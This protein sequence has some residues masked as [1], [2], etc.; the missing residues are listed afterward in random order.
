V[1]LTPALMNSA[2]A[3]NRQAVGSTTC[4]LRHFDNLG[5]SKWLRRALPLIV[6]VDA[7]CDPN[8]IRG[9]GQ[10]RAKESISTRRQHRLRKIGNSGATEPPGVPRWGGLSTATITYPGST[11]TGLCAYIKPTTTGR[12]R[13]VHTR[14]T[15]RTTRLC[16]TRARPI[17]GSAN[18]ARGVPRWPRHIIELHLPRPNHPAGSTPVSRHAILPQRCEA[19]P[20]KLGVSPMPASRACCDL[21]TVTLS[22][23]MYP[24]RGSA[25]ECR[26]G[27]D[28]R[29]FS[30]K[31]TALRHHANGRNVARNEKPAVIANK[32]DYGPYFLAFVRRF[33]IRAWSYDETATRQRSGPPAGDSRPGL[34]RTVTSSWCSSSRIASHA[35]DP[36]CNFRAAGRCS[37]CSQQFDGRC[38]GPQVS[39]FSAGYGIYVG[40][41][42]RSRP[43]LQATYPTVVY[44]RRD[45]P[46]RIRRGR[47]ASLRAPHDSRLIAQARANLL[48]NRSRSRGS[49]HAH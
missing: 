10:C 23:R 49:P 19:I 11:R 18:P 34:C 1:E 3:P 28:A 32:G 14:L 16:R 45:R 38:Q 17:N 39:S 37:H 24:M 4:P 30:M 25:R 29:P 15:P 41:A 22:S 40:L 35:H 13:R 42:R 44:G 6:L 20:R 21:T 48:G 36:D 7:G 26:A 8:A 43:M 27:G 47:C 2:G 46:E 5:L 12:Q 9:S 31:P 33:E